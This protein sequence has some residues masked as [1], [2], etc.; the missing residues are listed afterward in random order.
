VLSSAAV[1]PPQTQI[2][3]VLAHS[4]VHRL[5]HRATSSWVGAARLRARRVHLGDNGAGDATATG[6]YIAVRNITF[7]AAGILAIVYFSHAFSPP[8]VPSDP[9]EAAAKSYYN[10]KVGIYAAVA[11]YLGAAPLIMTI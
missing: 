3:D 8:P 10:S 1:R 2:L 11:F 9:V 4:A 5:T 6:Q 7:C